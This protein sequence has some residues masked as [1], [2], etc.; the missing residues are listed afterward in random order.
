[1]KRYLIYSVLVVAFVFAVV[2]LSFVQ[3]R[4]REED[5]RNL[6]TVNYFAFI[7]SSIKHASTLDALLQ[8]GKTE[9]AQKIVRMG[10]FLDLSE[11]DRLMSD[12]FQAELRKPVPYESLG[13]LKEELRILEEEFFTAA[14]KEAGEHYASLPSDLKPIL[15]SREF[16]RKMDR[17]GL[18]KKEP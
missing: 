15:E 6:R 5:R 14:V 18:P 4:V 8:T 2:L 9:E 11:L 13:D 17:L 12:D 7:K 1:M 3:L 10:I 16:L